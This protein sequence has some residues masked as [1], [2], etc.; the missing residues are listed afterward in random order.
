MNMTEKGDRLLIAAIEDKRVQCEERCMMTH[1]GFLDMRQAAEAAAFV[2]GSDALLWGGYEDAERRI[3]IFLPEY[4]TEEDIMTG[5]DCP[6]C[7]LRVTLPKNGGGK[8]SHRDYLGSLLALGIDRSVA[9]DILVRPDGADIIVLKGMADY[10]QRNYSGA[11]RTVF[12]KSETLPLSELDPGV[13]ETYEKRDTVASLRLDGL[14][15]SAFNLS[16]GKA[17]EAIKQGLVSLNSF[18]A[19]KPDMAVEE[20]SR[21]VLRGMGKAV[22]S[23]IGGTTRKDRITITWTRFK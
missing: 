11:G 12:A 7:I 16:R 14:V 15:A 20:G 5:D 22:L 10:L 23:N 9:G 3:C 4:M 18:P 8:L 19:D 17:Q 13:Q 21:L 1:T 2:K 6:L